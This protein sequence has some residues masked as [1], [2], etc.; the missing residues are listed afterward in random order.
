[1]LTAIYKS[2]KKEQTYLFVKQR[3]DFTD[4]PEAL[5]AMFGKPSLVTI[6]NL[7]TKEKL[8]FADIDKVRES[9][10]EQGFYLQLPPPKED[11]L[12]EHKAANKAAN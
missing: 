4:V 1:M 5:M 8:G 11:L 9:L 3:D 7:Q 2:T 12:A 10:L 6:V